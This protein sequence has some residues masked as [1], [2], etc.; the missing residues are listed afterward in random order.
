VKSG[1]LLALPGA[2]ILSFDEAPLR[3]V[4]YDELEHVRLPRDFLNRPESYLRHL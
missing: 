4:P 1:L 3:G 2:A